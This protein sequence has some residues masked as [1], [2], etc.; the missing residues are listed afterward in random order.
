[1]KVKARLLIVDDEENIRNILKH[2]FQDAGYDVLTSN[3]GLKALQIVNKFQPDIVLLD[4]NLPKLDG[5]QVLMALKKKYPYIIVIMITA[6]GEVSSA[7]EAIKN[8]AYDYVEKPF[9][10]EKIILLLKRALEHFKLTSEI[11]VL[12]KTVNNHYSF[13][14]IIGI[15]EK[16][17]QVLE[18]VKCVS[19]T[20]ATVLI[21]GESGTGKELIAQAIH[22]N[23]NRKNANMVTVNCGAIPLTLIENELFG[24]EKGSYTDAREMQPGKFEQANEGTLFLDEIGELPL[25]AQVK[26][27][28]VLEDRK[29]NRIGGKKTIPVNIRL[30]S[31]TNR[32]LEEKIQ[33]GAFRLDLFYRLNIFTILIPPLRERKDDIPLLADHFIQK[34]NQKLNVRIDGLSI[35]T[36]EMLIGYHW[37]GNIRDLENAIQSAMIVAKSGLLLPN[38]LPVRLQYPNIYDKALASGTSVN[39]NIN[40]VSALVEKEALYEALKQCKYNRTNTAKQLNI[41]RKTL[42]NKMK[43][44]GFLDY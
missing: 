28:R 7:V 37:P 22:F 8:G 26:L 25:D 41:S 4:K 9:D 44:Y 6:Y 14:N 2:L 32:N 34:Y 42:F 21:T 24:H 13:D 35:E 18:H 5:M 20:D 36:T 19:E 1:M 40:E 38:H 30:I 11:Q 16:I 12:R 15:S 33:I 27:L 23:S 17:K 31:A 39:G 3:D 43:K 10:N 29:I